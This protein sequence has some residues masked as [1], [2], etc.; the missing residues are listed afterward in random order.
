VTRKYTAR[1]HEK[2]L[3]ADAHLRDAVALGGLGKPCARLWEGID[4][5]QTTVKPCGEPATHTARLPDGTRAPVCDD[6][7]EESRLDGHYVTIGTQIL[8]EGA[9]LRRSGGPSP[10]DSFIREYTVRQ[11]GGFAQLVELRYGPE[12]QDCYVNLPNGL[13]PPR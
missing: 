6:C 5:D 4:G 3:D 7:A 12:A 2:A 10:R 13:I 11:R 8:S 1:M 9:S